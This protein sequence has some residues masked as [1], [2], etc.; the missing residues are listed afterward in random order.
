MS[1]LSLYAVLGTRPGVSSIEL[2]AAYVAAALAAHPDKGGSAETF[3]AV[4]LAWEALRDMT[5]DEIA[6]ASNLACGNSGSGS[7]ANIDMPRFSRVPI[8]DTVPL[9]DWTVMEMVESEA[10]RMVMSY[11][12]RMYYSCRCGGNYHLSV[13]DVTKIR[14][15][16]SITAACDGCSLSVDSMA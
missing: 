13:I 15:G 5:E 11:S 12:C 16:H 3:T 7:S 8:R 2:R 6:A 10:E 1:T 14:S 9:S 4:Q